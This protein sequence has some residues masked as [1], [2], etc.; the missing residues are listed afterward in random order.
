M[1]KS[2]F[3]YKSFLH[4]SPVHFPLKFKILYSPA[5]Q[6]N[7][8]ILLTGGSGFLGKAIVKEL[9][10]PGSPLSPSLLRIFDV[11]TYSGPADSRIEMVTGDIRDA[12]A[13]SAACRG[14]DLVIHSAAVVDWGTK[15]EKEVLDVNFGGTEN[16]VNACMEHHVR[17][18]VYTSSLDAVFEGKPLVNINEET[19]YPGNHPNMYCRSKY[20]SEKLVLGNNGR[21]HEFFSGS[22]AFVPRFLTTC[23]LRPADIYG[24]GDPYHIGSLINM[25]K[26]GF[27]C[28]VGDR[29]SKTKTRQSRQ[30][31][32]AACLATKGLDAGDSGG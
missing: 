6:L 11:S 18:L 19:P 13:V 25:A 16:V 30:H 22:S 15:P 12:Q 23:A 24:E 4:L 26:S 7:P 5:N 1:Q 21:K 28:K 31:A 14:I 2:N 29:I 17:H 8:S 32:M 3:A 20:L 10:A 27:L 9:L